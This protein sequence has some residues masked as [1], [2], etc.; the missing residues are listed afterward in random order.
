MLGGKVESPLH[1]VSRSAPSCFCSNFHLVETSRLNSRQTT[2]QAAFEISFV[3]SSTRHMQQEDEEEGVRARVH[4]KQQ[5][6]SKAGNKQTLRNNRS[7]TNLVRQVRIG[8]SGSI[9]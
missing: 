8:L 7:A 2:N 1:S 6:G 5:A 3:R 9:M 4:S